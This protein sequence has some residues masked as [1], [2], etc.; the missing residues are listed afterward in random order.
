MMPWHGSRCAS[1][2]WG[3]LFLPE[4]WPVRDLTR[5]ESVNIMCFRGCCEAADSVRLSEFSINGKVIQ[6]LHPQR[7]SILPGPYDRRGYESLRSQRVDKAKWSFQASLEPI[8]K[9]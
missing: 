2:G 4:P 6:L 7:L 8:A 3:G 1:Q 5:N 9:E